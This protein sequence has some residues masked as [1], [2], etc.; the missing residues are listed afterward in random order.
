[1]L[2]IVQPDPIHPTRATAR[3]LG[4]REVTSTAAA[5]LAGITAV[6]ID[7]LW[8]GELKANPTPV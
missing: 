4:S 3:L 6:I 8:P 1:M 2:P 7:D 5:L